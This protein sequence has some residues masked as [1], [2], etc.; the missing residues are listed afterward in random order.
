VDDD[1]EENLKKV[2][3][4]PLT[5][6]QPI[7]QVFPH[8]EENRLHIIVQA[9]PKGQ[10]TSGVLRV[11]VSMKSLV[12]S[13]TSDAGEEVKRDQIGGLHQSAR[14]FFLLSLSFKHR[15]TRV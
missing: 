7:L 15:F 4:V 13:T 8:V 5:P 2:D 3:L 6:L 11:A 12:R 1:L 9:P 10:F 14:N